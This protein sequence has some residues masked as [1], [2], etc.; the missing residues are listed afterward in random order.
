MNTI[1]S[2][3]SNFFL[4]NFLQ[5]DP[6]SARDLSSVE[7]STASESGEAP[8]L[9]PSR[10]DQNLAQ[11]SQG[12]CVESS[13]VQQNH[14]V[15]FSTTS[16]YFNDV[17]VGKNKNEYLTINNNSDCPVNF[18]SNVPSGFSISPN[19]GHIVANSSLTILVK[20]S[21]DAIQAYENKNYSGYLNFYDNSSGAS[22]GYV[23]LS[24]NGVKKKN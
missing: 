11:L 5:A 7:E 17:D 9:L 3:L 19:T 21:P 2:S 15:S 13:T 22:L 23:W 1:F 8:S 6:V 4:E 14:E 16:L 24:G 12:K 20:F 18:Y 10:P